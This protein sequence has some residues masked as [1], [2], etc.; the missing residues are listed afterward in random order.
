[1]MFDV[2]C[3]GVSVAWVIYKPVNRKRFGAIDVMFKRTSVVSYALV[4]NL[5]VSLEMTSFKNDHLWALW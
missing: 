4:G 5:L 1:M 3:I 2:Y